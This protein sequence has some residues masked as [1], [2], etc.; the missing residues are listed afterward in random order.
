MKLHCCLQTGIHFLFFPGPSLCTITLIRMSNNV[1]LTPIVLT[2]C[3]IFQSSGASHYLASQIL[4]QGRSMPASQVYQW[5]RG[6]RPW[7]HASKLKQSKSSPLEYYEPLLRCVS[8]SLLWKLLGWV[9]AWFFPVDLFFSFRLFSGFLL[10]LFYEIFHL[11]IQQ[12]LIVYFVYCFRLRGQSC[13][14]DKV[15][16]HMDL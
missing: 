1:F 8:H 5:Q 9:C 3:R 15:P 4:W 6:L 13:E 2:V 16:S 11:F 14:D 12:T 7:P 10:Q